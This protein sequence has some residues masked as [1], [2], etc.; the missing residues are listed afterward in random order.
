MQ[1]EVRYYQIWDEPNIAPHWGNRWINPVEYAQMLRLAAAAI[2][3]ADPD[4]AILLGALAPTADR[5]H[6]A[7]DEVYFLRR[8]VAAGAAPYFDAVAIQP[9]GF[10]RTPEDPKQQIDGF[11][12]Y[13]TVLVRRAMVSAGIGHKPLIAARF[14]WNRQPHSPWSAVSQSDQADFAARALELAYVKWPWLAGMAWA[15]DEPT[16]GANDPAWGFA[17]N[18]E[19]AATVAGWQAQTPMQRTQM[20]APAAH[21]WQRWGL[22]ALALALSI[23]RLRAALRIP[24]WNAWRAAYRSLAPP[25]HALLWALLLAAYLFAMWPPLVV[26]CWAVAAALILA[27]PAHGLWLAAA[28]LPFYFQHKEM[29]WGEVSLAIAPSTAAALCLLPALAAHSLRNR[30]PAGRWDVLAVAWVAVV[31][32]SASG[33]WNW[34]AY[35][36]G[37]VE[38]VLTPLV[39]YFAVRAFTRSGLDRRTVLIALTAGGALVAAAGLVQ[40][41]RGGGAGVD[42]VR[43]LVGPYF[44]ANHAALYLERTLFVAVG[45]AL[46]YGAKNRWLCALPAAIATAI[47][48]AALILTAS[49]GAILL[50]IPAGIIVLALLAVTGDRT[51]SQAHPGA[52]RTSVLSPARSPS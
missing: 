27:Q 12:L 31:A 9:L 22:L 46:F 3:E 45:L 13:R 1:D 38:F 49:R 43:R 29:H 24:P 40:W 5:G 23:W 33:V 48:A 4:A 36:R 34:P 15:I 35:V 47:V 50:G 52:R 11:N 41:L 39:L 14:G 19:L 44:S 51:R 18:D 20:G 17:L 26:L 30:R 2:R 32:A 21:A 25:V 7:M 28:V 16:G 6:L 37:V 42:S 8:L 10:G